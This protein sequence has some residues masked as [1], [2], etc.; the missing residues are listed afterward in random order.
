VLAAAARF[1]VTLLIVLSRVLLLTGLVLA[2]LL[3]LTRLV[4]TWLLVTRENHA[5]R[6]ED[7][8]FFLR[9]EAVAGK[10]D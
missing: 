8:I 2:G 9:G 5:L 7:K 10:L 3:R 4:L 6:I 1:A